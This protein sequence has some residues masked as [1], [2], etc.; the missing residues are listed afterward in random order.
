MVEIA[1]SILT[2]EEENSTKTFYNLESAG[3]NYFHI[4]VMD[5]KFVE[6]NT[7]E[8]MYKYASVIKQISTLPLDVHLMVENIKENIDKYL[9]LEPSIITIHYEACKSDEEVFELINYI[10]DN[11]IKPGISI[12][13]MTGVESIEKFLPYIHMLLVMTVEPGKGGQKLIPETVEKVKKLKEHI[14]K[15]NLDV[16]IEVDRGSK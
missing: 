14:S 13:P 8:M 6:K 5:G 12:K 4:D 11:N 9:E 10:K 1:T 3:I 15:N 16:Y 7:D 2:V